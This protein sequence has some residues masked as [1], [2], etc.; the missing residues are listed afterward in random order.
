M[1]IPYHYYFSVYKKPPAFKFPEVF[2]FDTGE[3][4]PIL[5]VGS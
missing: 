1:L 5:F 3:L 2:L 4:F